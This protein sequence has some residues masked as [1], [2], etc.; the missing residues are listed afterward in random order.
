MSADDRLQPSHDRL[1]ADS[2]LPRLEARVLLEHATGRT[3]SWLIAHGD[4]PATPQAAI[5]FV[6]LADRR[7]SDGEPIAY[8]TGSREFHGVSLRVGPGVLIPRP[9]TE[10]LVDCTL[11]LLVNDKQIAG[12]P[13]ALLELGTG[14]GAI[15]LAIAAARPSLHIVASDCSAAALGQAQANGSRLGLDRSIEWRLGD[16]WDAVGG[17]ERFGVIVSNPPYIAEG[18]PHLNQG[19]LR[20][21]P[22]SALASGQDGLD[23]IRTIVTGACDHLNEG[24]WLLL[25]HGFEQGAQVRRLMERAGFGSVETLKDLEGRDRVTR[26][27]AAAG[28]QTP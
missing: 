13:D 10:L 22:A 14:S 7:R 20:H 12:K 15:A 8:L 23:A 3:R 19:D 4:E 25:E 18:D 17:D 16:W 11:D 9:E 26:G 28:H 2:G 27:Q 5:R 24:G 1:V 21:E 6:G